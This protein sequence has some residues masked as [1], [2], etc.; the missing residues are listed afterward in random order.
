MRLWLLRLANRRLAKRQG[1]LRAILSDAS[2]ESEELARLRRAFAELS[3]RHQAALSL[4]LFEAL[5]PR[6]ISD[7]LDMGGRRSLSLL[8]GALRQVGTKMF[9][10][11]EEGS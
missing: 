5:P 2:G 4:A 8:R 9:A 6:D 11:N 1:R 10:Q 3:P 7:A